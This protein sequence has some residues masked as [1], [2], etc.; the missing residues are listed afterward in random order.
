MRFHELEPRNKIA[1]TRIGDCYLVMDDLERALHYYNKALDIGYDFYAL[2]GSARVYTKLKEYANALEIYQRMAD[3]EKG[4]YR[5]YQEL[6]AYWEA[7]GDDER[8]A[9]VRALA[10]SLARR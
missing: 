6:I 7:V 9:Q 5:Y 1:I 2:V 10:S 8:A 4:N 3:R